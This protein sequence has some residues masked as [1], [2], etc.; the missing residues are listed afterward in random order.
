MITIFTPRNKYFR[1]GISAR[2]KARDV[3]RCNGG[4]VEFYHCGM[5]VGI[6]G[7]IN[8]D[9]CIANE[10]DRH[11]TFIGLCSTLLPTCNLK[12]VGSYVSYHAKQIIE[13]SGVHVEHHI[14]CDTRYQ[15]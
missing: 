13:T 3:D 4:P 2:R 7:I 6:M 1:S 11:G 10:D 15:L 14:N 5:E 9:S 8:P 12:M